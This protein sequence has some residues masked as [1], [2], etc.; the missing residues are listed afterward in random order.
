MPSDDPRRDPAL[1]LSQA[2]VLLHRAYAQL[3][4]AFGH[5]ATLVTPDGPLAEVR[6]VNLTLRRRGVLRA[7]M[8]GAGPSILDAVDEA[9]RRA[10]SDARYG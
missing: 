8:S 2:T 9:A 3:L 10:A 4:R 7:S 6:A 1:T 5:E